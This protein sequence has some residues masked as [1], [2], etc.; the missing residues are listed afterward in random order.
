MCRVSAAAVTLALC[1]VGLVPSAHAATLLGG[2]SAGMTNVP[3]ADTAPAGQ[4]T[5]G[6]V[7]ELGGDARSYVRYGLTDDLELGIAVG[8][9]DPF[10]EGSSWPV[11]I[12]ARYRLLKEHDAVP[13]LAAG[14]EGSS[15]Y[16]VASHRLPGPL[17]RGHVGVRNF[18]EGLRVFAGI[19]AT[20]NPV[21]VRRPGAIPEPI[22]TV[23]VDY[24]G[25][26]L[27]AG[28]TLQFSPWLAVD[29]GV[30]DKGALQLVAGVSI[31][32]GF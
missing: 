18:Q 9:P 27:G 26:F 29:V 24:D 30:R 17:L 19:D 4:M 11:G 3:T 6:L 23:G 12:L 31:S 21:T 28:A 25:V 15:G 2:R 10:G 5:L 1:L 16:L 22:V 14:I 8:N 7:A 32:P 13:G 20:L